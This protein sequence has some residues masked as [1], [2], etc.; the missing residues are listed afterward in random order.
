MRTQV[1]TAKRSS[2]HPHLEGEM[3]KT[4]SFGRKHAGGETST[5]MRRIV[6]MANHPGGETSKHGAKR[7]GGETARGQNVQLP[8]AQRYR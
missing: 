3:H 8:M 2:V 1:S 7:L 6:Q 4:V 5:C